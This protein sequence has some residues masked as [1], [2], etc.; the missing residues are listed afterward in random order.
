MLLFNMSM[1]AWK[2]RERPES[3]HVTSCGTT[4][5]KTE[6]TS[7]LNYKKTKH[8]G[9]LLTFH[10]SCTLNTMSKGIQI[11]FHHQ[12]LQKHYNK[13]KKNREEMNK[14]KLNYGRNAGI[15]NSKLL[16]K[17]LFRSNS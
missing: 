10:L 4:G 6:T 17:Q 3:D 7:L 13:K 14:K 1:K 2:R 16:C 15:I 12:Q 8:M 5:S 11:D 9:K